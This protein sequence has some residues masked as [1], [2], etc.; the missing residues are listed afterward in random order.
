MR[1]LIV[2]SGGRE[3]AL[4]WVAQ[5]A[6]H[7]VL[8]APG[9]GGTPSNRAVAA[10][11]VDGVV[12]LAVD[13]QADLVLVGPEGP[14]VAGLVDALDAKGVPAFG[15]RRAAARLEGSKAFA[16][17]AMA[18]W[19][20]PTAE[21][22]TVRNLPD[23]LAALDRFSAPPV[24][25]ASGL[26]AGKGV[27]VPQDRPGAEAAL[28]AMFVDRAFGAAADEVVV[29]ERLEGREVSVLAICAG[30]AYQLLLPAQDHKR[31]LDG[32]AGPNTG[33]MGA[34]APSEALPEGLLDRIGDTMIA[35]VLHGMEADGTPYHG[36]LYAG[37]M[38][39]TEGPRVLEY[40]CR[41]GDPETQVILP[42]WRDDPVEVFR[43]AAGGR[44][45]DRAPLA[46][47]D[48]AAVTVVVAA[49]GYPERARGG[50]PISGIEQA[51]AAGCVVFHAGTARSPAGPV[52]AGGRVLAVTATG[53]DLAAATRRAYAGV[54]EISFP[55]SQ[56]RRDIGAQGGEGS[57]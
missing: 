7:T 33:G 2:G 40:N 16:K 38:L 21:S 5:R 42:L 49:E 54:G 35:P 15:P 20:I 24:I 22:V 18:R 46:W 3:H 29:E 30:T 39:S 9:N 53:A 26:A 19:G 25:K 48:E 14:L 44:L 51:E 8:C 34:F 37:V 10:T 28:R 4:A 56:H 31:L 27:L 47:S 57:A 1:V 55:G 43:A 12:R 32:D 13:E 52:T 50:D 41:F 23:G 6:G 45:A 11:D 17:Q 36:V